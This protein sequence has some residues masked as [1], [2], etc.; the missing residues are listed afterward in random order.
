MRTLADVIAEN[1]PLEVRDAIGWT[2]RASLTLWALHE[3]GILHGRVSPAAILIADPGC[4]SDGLLIRPSQLEDAPSYQS[5]ERARGAPPSKGDDMWAIGITLYYVLTGEL[6]YPEGVLH[7]ARNGN[8]RPPPPLAVHGAALDVMQPVLDR[9]IRADRRDRI[10]AAEEIVAGL[11]DLSPAIADVDPLSIERPFDE[12]DVIAPP[13]SPAPPPSKNDEAWR[14]LTNNSVP[15][16]ARA[17]A[18]AAKD[19]TRLM[20]WWGVRGCARCR[21]RAVLFDH[22]GSAR[23]IDSRHVGYRRPSAARRHSAGSLQ[24][25]RRPEVA[26]RRAAATR[27]R[28]AL[29]PRSAG[30]RR[31]FRDVHLEPLQKGRVRDGKGG[32]RLPLSHDEPR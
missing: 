25:I 7:A 17:S 3:E 20:M 6:P 19:P 10:K 1:G 23:D 16:P 5:L 14:L 22:A 11:R 30:R 9:L 31:G 13:D 29:G 15:P 21:Y 28:R 18:T 2:L 32:G 27:S 8:V 4:R 24:Q 26:N 12:T